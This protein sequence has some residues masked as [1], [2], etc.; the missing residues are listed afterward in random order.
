MSPSPGEHPG[1]EVAVREASL[2]WREGR[3]QKELASGT[4]EQV[5]LS[6]RLKI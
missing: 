2:T 4:E 1:D 5:E 6:P 3:Q